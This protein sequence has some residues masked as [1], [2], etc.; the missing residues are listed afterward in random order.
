MVVE[1]GKVKAGLY[2]LNIT[3]FGNPVGGA[4]KVMLWW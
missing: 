3:A 2:Q 4:K 1:I